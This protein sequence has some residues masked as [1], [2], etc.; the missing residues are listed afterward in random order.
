MLPVPRAVYVAGATVAGGPPAGSSSVVDVRLVEPSRSQACR[1]VVR[2][3]GTWRS[4]RFSGGPGVRGR[5]GAGRHGC[6]G[7]GIEGPATAGPRQSAPPY[8]GQG[9]TAQG[10]RDSRRL[11]HPR[12]MPRWVSRGDATSTTAQTR[13]VVGTSPSPPHQPQAPVDGPAAGT[14][15]TQQPALPR[16]LPD[17]HYGFRRHAHLSQWPRTRGRRVA[18]WAATLSRVTVRAPAALRASS[19]RVPCSI[20]W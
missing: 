5:L 4:F 20:R 17:R 7:A 19:M 2:S 16:R 13:T 11:V 1:R 18:A 12:V 3:R 8:Q 6:V 15:T 9:L 10:A 14:L